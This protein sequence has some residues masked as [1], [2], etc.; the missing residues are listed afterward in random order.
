MWKGGTTAKQLA[1]LSNVNNQIWN[2]KPTAV[3]PQKL[4]ARV[5]NP[6]VGRQGGNR[7]NTFGKYIYLY[8]IM[9]ITYIIY[10]T[11]GIHSCTCPAL[12]MEEGR[13]TLG[14]RE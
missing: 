11:S 2:L 7:M 3:K 4:C 13:V 8:F 14:P 10:I 5:H 1:T 12:K 9:K 6:T